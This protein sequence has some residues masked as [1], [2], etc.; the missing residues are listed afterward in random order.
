MTTHPREIECQRESQ[1]DDDTDASCDGVHFDSD[2][3]SSCESFSSCS[4]LDSLDQCRGKDDDHDEQKADGLGLD[5]IRKS[6]RTAVMTNVP[7]H[8]VPDG[9]SQFLYPFY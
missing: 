2:A 9:M 8:Q 7:P 4:S 5:E 6:N 1:G 3:S